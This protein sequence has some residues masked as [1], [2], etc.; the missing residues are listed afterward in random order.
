MKAYVNVA[1]AGG[2][3]DHGT[4]E[5]PGKVLRAALKNQ[6]T[7][8]LWDADSVTIEFEGGLSIHI[9]MED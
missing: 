4:I 2:E 9:H 5:I 6:A 1:S 8:K 3:K 7:L